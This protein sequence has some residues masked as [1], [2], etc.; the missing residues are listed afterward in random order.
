MSDDFEY[1]NRYQYMFELDP[2][3]LVPRDAYRFIPDS[4]LNR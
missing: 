1:D 3:C 4:I 2:S